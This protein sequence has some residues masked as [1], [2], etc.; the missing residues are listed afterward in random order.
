MT[1][2]TLD[3]ED[4]EYILSEFEKTKKYLANEIKVMD[5]IK[6]DHMIIPTFLNQLSQRINL[7]IDRTFVPLDY[8][9]GNLEDT[10]IRPK[11]IRK[12][13]SQRKEY[14]RMVVDELNGLSENYFSV[15]GA[16]QKD[17]GSTLKGLTKRLE[18][19]IDKEI[20]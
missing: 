12:F 10:F 16:F 8:M 3:N 4:K 14:L 19:E 9:E 20:I 13:I 11:I 2:I 17:L 7:V 18:S 6:D 1:Q 5:S 15:E